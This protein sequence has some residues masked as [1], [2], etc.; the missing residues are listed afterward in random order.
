MNT[1]SNSHVNLETREV[2]V[3]CKW[4]TTH[5]IDV[6]ALHPRIDED[7][8]DSILEIEDVQA[9]AS[10]DLIDWEVVDRA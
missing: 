3:R 5:T 1:E 6:P 10:A 7:D 8:L 9:D 4:V 2:T